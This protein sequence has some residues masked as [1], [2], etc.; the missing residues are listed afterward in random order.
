[1]VPG[2]MSDLLDDIQPGKTSNGQQDPAAAFEGP[3]IG[4]ILPSED[5][6]VQGPT[7]GLSRIRNI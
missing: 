2:P 4:G 3:S 6:D 1:M 7:K 5:G